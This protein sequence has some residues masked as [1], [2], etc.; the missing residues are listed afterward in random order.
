MVTTNCKA[1]NDLPNT[2]ITLT[3]E[4]QKYYV[5]GALKTL[6]FLYTFKAKIRKRS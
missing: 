5:D 1:N 3:V 6:L 2:P 4:K